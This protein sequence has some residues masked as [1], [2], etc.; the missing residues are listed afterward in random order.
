MMRLALALPLFPSASAAEEGAR[1]A[2]KLAAPGASQAIEAIAG[3]AAVL[4]L[5][6]ALGWAVRRFGRLPTGSKGAVRVL[7]GVALG[8]RERAV[9]VAVGPTRLL[10]G[11]APGQV[12]TLHVLPAEPEA[13]VDFAGE[14]AAAKG[15]SVR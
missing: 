5:I 3:L 4:A 11:V 10:L 1:V 15:E 6:L 9:L 13:S 8:A 2:S 7:G 12:R 14:L